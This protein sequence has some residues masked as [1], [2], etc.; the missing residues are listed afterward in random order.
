MQA[1]ACLLSSVI[2]TTSVLARMV[3]EQL[4]PGRDNGDCSRW[5]ESNDP[6]PEIEKIELGLRKGP[7]AGQRMLLPLEM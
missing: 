7:H 5:R 2:E 6:Q 4:R 1:V 3:P